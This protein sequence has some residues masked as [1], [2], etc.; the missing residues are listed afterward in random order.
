MY[1]ACR[2]PHCGGRQHRFKN[3][4]NNGKICA[5]SCVPALP[6]FPD[7]VIRSLLKVSYDVHRFLSTY[8]QRV[9]ICAS[10]CVHS[11]MKQVS[12]VGLFWCV[13]ISFE[14]LLHG[15]NVQ[16]LWTCVDEVSGPSQYVSFVITESHCKLLV[17]LRYTTHFKV[18]LVGLFWRSRFITNNLYRSL[19]TYFLPY[20]SQCGSGTAHMPRCTLLLGVCFDVYRCLLTCFAIPQLEGK[21]SAATTSLQVDIFKSQLAAK[22]S[23]ENDYRANS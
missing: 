4:Q 23:T 17:W 22:F 6:R 12:C 13:Q 16:Q 14:T 15:K 7:V 5:S 19:L 11:W 21:T 10:S 20:L 1:I 2:S 9:K 18:W 3:K 8:L